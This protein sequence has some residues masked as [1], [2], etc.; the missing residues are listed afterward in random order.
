[1]KKHR[2]DT[3]IVS[4]RDDAVTALEGVDLQA[5]LTHGLDLRKLEFR[6]A[7]IA[8]I[9]PERDPVNIT[10]NEAAIRLEPSTHKVKGLG[11]VY[12]AGNGMEGV[13]RIMLDGREALTTRR[14]LNFVVIDDNGQI[15]ET[16]NFDTFRFPY[17]TNGL[18][19]VIPPS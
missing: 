3:I 9:Q 12:S 8:I 4:A 7:H 5:M 19:K 13:S 16:A 17:R 15:V 18:Y 2:T 11:E 6:G 10:D 14:G 1:M